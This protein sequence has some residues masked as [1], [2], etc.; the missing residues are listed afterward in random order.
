M[1]L[2]DKGIKYNV[3]QTAN[4]TGP[5]NC[6]RQ[7]G[8]EQDQILTVLIPRGGCRNQKGPHSRDPSPVKKFVRYETPSPGKSQLTMSKRFDDSG[9][10]RCSDTGTTSVLICFDGCPN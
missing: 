5:L 10:I 6:G 9:K 2:E 8:L 7:E 1:E 3:V 4:P